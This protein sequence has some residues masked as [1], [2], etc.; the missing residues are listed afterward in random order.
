MAVEKR[1]HVNEETYCFELPA[2]LRARLQEIAEI[3][4]RTLAAQVRLICEKYVE[5]Y[6][7]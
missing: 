1:K 7:A 3:E 4:H 6:H 5:D 2:E